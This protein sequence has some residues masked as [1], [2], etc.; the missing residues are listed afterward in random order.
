MQYYS[1]VKEKQEAHT[2]AWGHHEGRLSPVKDDKHDLKVLDRTIMRDRDWGSKTEWRDTMAKAGYHKGNTKLGMVEMNNLP[3]S[4]LEELH[5]RLK[6]KLPLFTMNIQPPGACVPAHE[7]TWY[8]WCDK[9]PDEMKNY[10]FADTRFFIIFLTEQET[11][12]FFQMGN[13]SV[14]WQPGDI[15]SMPYYTNHATANA[16]FTNKILIQCLGISE[17]S[18]K[19]ANE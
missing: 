12:H 5:T 3:P 10:T 2:G 13:Q 7:D 11:G 18:Y 19:K 9:Y 17:Q 4:L 14:H 1:L 6:M 8:K 15:F 16:G